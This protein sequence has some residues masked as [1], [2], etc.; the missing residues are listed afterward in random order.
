VQVR[1]NGSP[2]RCK[3]VEGGA[4]EGVV[5]RLLDPVLGVAPGQSA[6]FYNGDRVVGGGTVLRGGV[7]KE[8]RSASAVEAGVR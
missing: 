8:A 1:Y 6:V 2:V 5:V 4:G 3:V 7:R